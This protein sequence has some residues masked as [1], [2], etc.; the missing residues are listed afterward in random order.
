MMTRHARPHLSEYL[1]IAY[2]RMRASELQ[3]QSETCGLFEWIALQDS[4]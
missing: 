2:P 4:L 1:G 3:R